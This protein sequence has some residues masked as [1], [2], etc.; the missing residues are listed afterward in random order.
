MLP[1]PIDPRTGKRIKMTKQ[2]QRLADAI[3]ACLRT[4][5]AI[6]V[7]RAAVPTFYA[8]RDVTDNLIRGNE[9]QGLLLDDFEVMPLGQ[10]YAYPPEDTGDTVDPSATTSPS[11]STSASSTPE[12]GEA[13]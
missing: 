3:V 5:G 10:S 8:Q 4:Y 6:V 2:Q 7:D 12:P 13:Q 11:A 1:V 9:L